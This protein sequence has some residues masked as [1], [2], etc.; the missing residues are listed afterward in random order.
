[1]QVDSTIGAAPKR[2][3]PIVRVQLVREGT[4]TTTVSTIRGPR[5][6]AQLFRELIGDADREHFV[7]LMLDTKNA[8]RGLHTVSVGDLSSSIVH[9]REVFK[10]ALLSSAASLIFVHNH[11]S[12]DPTPSPEDIAVTRRLVE[13]GE[14]LGVE[15]LDHVVI[16]EGVHV[17]LKE[18]GYF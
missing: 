7:M 17:S 8:V 4:R 15:V 2:R 16:G 18:K 6:A 10:A 9:P 12:G 11:P 13:A 5:D 1:M 14:L 3:L